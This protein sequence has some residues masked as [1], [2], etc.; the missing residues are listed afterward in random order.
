[1]QQQLFTDLLPISLH[2]KVLFHETVRVDKL[3]TFFCYCFQLYI[4]YLGYP[5][6]NNILLLFWGCPTLEVGFG[7]YNCRLFNKFKGSRT[8]LSS[9]SG[10]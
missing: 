4:E 3:F 5:T 7:V 8:F 9:Y 6:L 1:M 10:L 2:P